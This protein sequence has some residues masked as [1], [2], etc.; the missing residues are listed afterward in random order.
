MESKSEVKSRR[1]KSRLNEEGM[2]KMKIMKSK[3]DRKMLIFRNS[4]GKAMGLI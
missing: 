4:K 1:E 2:E 3:M